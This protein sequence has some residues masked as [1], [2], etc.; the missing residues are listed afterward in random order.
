MSSSYSKVSKTH[1]ILH[2]MLNVA[3]TE[4]FEVVRDQFFQSFLGSVVSQGPNTPY[5]S[6]T[7]ASTPTPVDDDAN[8][9]ALPPKP[10]RT[11][12]HQLSL[13]TKAARQ[14]SGSL[15]GICKHYAGSGLFEGDE[16]TQAIE[17]ILQQPGTPYERVGR[18]LAWFKEWR[19][20]CRQQ[21]KRHPNDAYDTQHNKLQDAMTDMLL[22]VSRAMIF[23]DAHAPAKA[24]H[25][26][27]NQ[28]TKSVCDDPTPAM[29][30]PHS[31]FHYTT[32]PGKG[33]KEREERRQEWLERSAKYK[34]QLEHASPWTIAID[35]AWK[36]SIS[37]AQGS[38][39]SKT[40]PPLYSLAKYL[41]V[42]DES[43]W[44]R[45][46]VC[47]A[48]VM[49]KVFMPFGASPQSGLDIGLAP[50]ATLNVEA[51]D[52]WWKEQERSGAKDWRYIRRSSVMLAT[53]SKLDDISVG[54]AVARLKKFGPA[55]VVNGAFSNEDN[56]IKALLLE[57]I[58]PELGAQYNTLRQ[59][60]EAMG[61][62]P[63]VIIE[64]LNATLQKNK[65]SHIEP[66]LDMGNLFG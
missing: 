40:V 25:V 31:F 9:I 49:E 11:P 66:E 36:R 26:L 8:A 12:E 39:S 33:Q 53:K 27:R 59:V 21:N 34:E 14:F 32:Y 63:D 51:Y 43:T 13:W 55:E 54:D 30:K 50:T 22:N 57:R 3:S 45:E 46:H 65:G 37:F 48:L 47:N 6:L 10:T 16:R 61:H 35:W 29:S 5:V 20:E 1:N 15:S 44:S 19:K 28:P 64:S 38:V 7:A 17:A 56:D 62:M 58:Q 42:A 60:E 52:A 24:L 18:V 4:A 2:T 23:E 41:M